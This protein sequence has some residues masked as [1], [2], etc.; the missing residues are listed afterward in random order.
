M[1]KSQPQV[2]PTYVV[3]R[4]RHQPSSALNLFWILQVLV[5]LV[6]LIWG[7][8]DRSC[9]SG[10]SCQTPARRLDL[11]TWSQPK[12]VAVAVCARDSVIIL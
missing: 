5:G 10:V 12:G 8:N 4:E 11:Q 6:T 2:G 7:K 9:V 3:V 1:E